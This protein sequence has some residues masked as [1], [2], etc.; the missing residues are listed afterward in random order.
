MVKCLYTKALIDT[1]KS[2]KIN[3]G[4]FIARKLNLNEMFNTDVMHS[5]GERN[6]VKGRCCTFARNDVL[7]MI[8]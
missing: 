7:R 1:V 4:Q 3:K 5:T 2:N 6:L 8:C